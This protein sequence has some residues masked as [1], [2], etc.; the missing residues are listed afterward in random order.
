MNCLQHPLG[1]SWRVRSRG[2]RRTHWYLEHVHLSRK[3]SSR[4][5]VGS[6]PGRLVR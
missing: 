3:G 5:L 6:S 2:R 4:I 1:S